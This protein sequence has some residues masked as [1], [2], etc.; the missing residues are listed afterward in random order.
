MTK[1]DKLA[2]SRR[3]ALAIGWKPEQITPAHLVHPSG[4][5]ELCCWLVGRQPFWFN[6]HR[7]TWA[8]AERYN[9]FPVRWKGQ[10]RANALDIPGSVT[11]REETPELA[12]A[13]AVI[14]AHERT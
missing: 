1:A 6:D 3:L 10:W 8:I 2:I 9:A 13:M 7:V 4:K 11:V 5:K 12:V 14:R